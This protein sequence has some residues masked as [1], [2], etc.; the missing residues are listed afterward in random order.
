MMIGTALI[1]GVGIKKADATALIFSPVCLSYCYGADADANLYF[2]GGGGYT[3]ANISYKGASAGASLPGD[4]LYSVTEAP[5]PVTGKSGTLSSAGLFDSL[6][7]SDAQLGNEVKLFLVS[8]WALNGK[9]GSAEVLLGANAITYS[10]VYGGYVDSA[11][12]GVDYLY[13]YT[14]G[15]FSGVPPGNY[16]QTCI[17]HG[18]SYPNCTYSN[19]G[20]LS[21][22]SVLELTYP[23]PV[24][25]SFFGFSAGIVGQNG[26]TIDPSIYV[27]IPQGVSIISAS[28]VNYP[29]F[30]P[31]NI[32]A[33]P[34][35]PTFWLMATGILGMFG[36]AGY[37][38]GK[39]SA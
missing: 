3:N 6:Y 10:T 14:Q 30:N 29:T 19:A 7:L 37:R 39:A 33:T 9:Y 36:W 25:D 20:T 16:L 11:Q 34:E 32:A 8:N 18:S 24:G 13:D 21:G 4:Y 2:I 22:T 1:F 26:A 31:N 27:D 23:L 28:G 12:K 17:Y 5:D 38:R 15:G 35:P